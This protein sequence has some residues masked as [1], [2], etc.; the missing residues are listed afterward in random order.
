MS[1]L[2]IFCQLINQ[3]IRKWTS[4]SYSKVTIYEFTKKR[5]RVKIYE[6]VFYSNK[7]SH[8]IPS[9]P[10]IKG[11]DVSLRNHSHLKNSFTTLTKI[12]SDLNGEIRQTK[13]R[14]S[15]MDS[16]S[17]P[18]PNPQSYLEMPWSFS[19]RFS[20]NV[21]SRN[22]ETA[23]K[24]CKSIFWTNMRLLIYVCSVYTIKRLC[25]EFLKMEI[26]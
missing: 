4:Y 11:K 26:I 21:L 19:S 3:R 13:R 25:M 1:F 9:Q 6:N 14:K 18:R 2:I 5:K 24:L 8:P 7:E 10:T 20:D 16:S 15:P 17:V 23:G 12:V 22:F